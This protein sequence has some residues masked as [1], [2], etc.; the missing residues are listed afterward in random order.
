MYESISKII[1]VIV[2]IIIAPSAAFGINPKQSLLLTVG[3]NVLL[4]LNVQKFVRIKKNS[5]FSKKCF[6]NFYTEPIVHDL[7]LS[8]LI[9]CTKCH[10]Y[11]RYSIMDKSWEI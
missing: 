8:A 11:L 5:L 2:I 6:V 10:H 3:E 7:Y 4:F 9:T 1:I